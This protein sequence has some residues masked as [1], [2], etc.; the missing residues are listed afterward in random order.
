MNVAALLSVCCPPLLNHSP[1]VEPLLA[2]LSTTDAWTIL[3]PTNDAITAALPLINVTLDEILSGSETAGAAVGA[4]LAFHVLPEGAFTARQIV[5]YTS[6]TPLLS[7]AGY[8][9]AGN[10]TITAPDGAKGNVTFEGEENSTATVIVPNIRASRAERRR[11][12]KDK[13]FIA[14]IVDG[15]L[16]PPAGVLAE[17]TTISAENAT[18]L[19][20]NVTLAPNAGPEVNDTLAG[21]GDATGADVPLPVGS[22]TTPAIGVAPVGDVAP[23]ATTPAAGTPIGVAVPVGVANVSGPVLVAEI[24]NATAGGRTPNEDALGAPPSNGTAASAP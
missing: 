23:N 6:I 24:N 11:L 18:E 21:E 14:H 13:N 7:A 5:R 1:D 2:N 15:V 12:G 16:L 10:L 19:P 3:V 8:P 20:G 4:L 22:T 17:A 9:E